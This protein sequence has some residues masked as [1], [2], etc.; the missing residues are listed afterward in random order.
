[1]RTVPVVGYLIWSFIVEKL[2]IC[3]LAWLIGVCT[4]LAQDAESV[5]RLVVRVQLF[6]VEQGVS[7]GVHVAS[8][9]PVESGCGRR[10]GIRQLGVFGSLVASSKVGNLTPFMDHFLA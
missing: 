9:R 3:L 7:F 6:V 8:G 2:V 10:D 5:T 1:M 4:L